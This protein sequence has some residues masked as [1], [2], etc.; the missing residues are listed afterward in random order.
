MVLFGINKVI[1][2]WSKQA[3]LQKTELLKKKI[4]VNTYWLICPYLCCCSLN[5]WLCS[6]VVLDFLQMWLGDDG[7]ILHGGAEVQSCCSLGS[8]CNERHQL[9]KHGVSVQEACHSQSCL[10]CVWTVA[11]T[12]GILQSQVRMRRGSCLSQLSLLLW[13]IITHLLLVQL[14]SFQSWCHYYY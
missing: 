10:A 9:D 13:I 14:S 12:W 2:I 1:W 7:S 5:L 6:A 11:T 8:L 4:V 3:K